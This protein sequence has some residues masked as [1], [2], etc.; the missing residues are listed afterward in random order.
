MRPVYI[1]GYLTSSSWKSLYRCDPAVP[2]KKRCQ[3]IYRQNISPQT[4]RQFL[5]VGFK[6]GK[7]K[8]RLLWQAYHHIYILRYVHCTDIWQP[9]WLLEIHLACV[10]NDPVI[11]PKTPRRTSAASI[12]A[13]QSVRVENP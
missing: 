2:P 5:L 3:P 7:I 9:D 8:G 11:L 13:K 10:I 6:R 12:G 4:S 1:F